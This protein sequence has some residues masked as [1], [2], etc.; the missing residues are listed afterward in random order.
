MKPTPRQQMMI[1]DGLPPSLIL[2]Q[3]QRKAAWDA[4]PPRPMPKFAEVKRGPSEIDLASLRQI[5]EN[6]KRNARIKFEN[7]IA[8][9]KE[10]ESF[11]PGSRW[12]TKTCR[13][14][15]PNLTPTKEERNIMPNAKGEKTVPEMTVEYNAICNSPAGKSLG[16]KQI[17]KF[18][19]SASAQA[20]LKQVW[21]KIHAMA[22]TSETKAPKAPKE[23]VKKERLPF[24]HAHGAIVEEFDFRCGSNREKLLHLLLD[25]FEGMVPKKSLGEFAGNVS[26]I[27]WVI[28]GKP[29]ANGKATVSQLQYELRETKEDGVKSYGLYRKVHA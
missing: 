18:R 27:T 1:D 21:A 15:H 2:S 6:E 22:E 12:D 10:R 11:V 28:N 26:G 29:G 23:K 8:R 4:N 9:A 3:E 20:R 7:R 13:Y 16:L 19:D 5:E 24:T 25:S 14:I 17:V